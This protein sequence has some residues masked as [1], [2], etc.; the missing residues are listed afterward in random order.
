M[1]E[2]GEDLP[3]DPMDLEAIASLKA[4]AWQTSADKASG[5]MRRRYEWLLHHSAERR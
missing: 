1:L 4:D 3:N 5:R 2:P